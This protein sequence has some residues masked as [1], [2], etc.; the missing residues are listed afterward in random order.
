MYAVF[1]RICGAQCQDCAKWIAASCAA[2]CAAAPVDSSLSLSEQATGAHADATEGSPGPRG[3]VWGRVGALVYFIL[4]SCLRKLFWGPAAELRRLGMLRIVKR[5]GSGL[6]MCYEDPTPSILRNGIGSAEVANSNGKPFVEPNRPMG[7]ASPYNDGDVAKSEAITRRNLL[8][9]VPSVA[10]AN[11]PDGNSQESGEK[12]ASVLNSF[13]C[14]VQVG[15]DI[16][17]TWAVGELELSSNAIVCE[18]SSSD[19]LTESDSDGV[20]SEDGGGESAAASNSGDCDDGQ[21][22]LSSNNVP[23]ISEG[24]RLFN[25]FTKGIL[26][27]EV[28]AALIVD[29]SL[30]PLGAINPESVE[31]A[32]GCIEA[33]LTNDALVW[34]WRRWL[35][36]VHCFSHST[37]QS[38]VRTVRVVFFMRNGGEISG[39]PRSAFS[40]WFGCDIAAALLAVKSARAVVRVDACSSPHHMRQLGR[41]LA[42]N[43]LAPEAVR[44]PPEG[45]IAPE[46]MDSGAPRGGIAFS[47]FKRFDRD[48]DGALDFVEI[49]ELQRAVNGRAFKSEA[50]YFEAL[51]EEALETDSS[52]NITFAGFQRAYG[53]AEEAAQSCAVEHGHGGGNR[54]NTMRRSL[55]EDILR[56]GLGSV[57][58]TLAADMHFSADIDETAAVE[59]GKN[60]QD[61]MWNDAAAKSVAILLRHARRA[62]ASFAFDSLTQFLM[63]LWTSVSENTAFAATIPTFMRLPGLIACHISALERIVRSAVTICRDITGMMGTEDTNNSNI[64]ANLRNIADMCSL[65]LDAYTSCCAALNGLMSVQYVTCGR[66]IR[67]HISRA[68]ALHVG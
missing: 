45:E 53:F 20:N 12:P 24:L 60:L 65:S 25:K 41:W 26:P 2:S 7:G 56:L 57:V 14:A 5:C 28:K 32:I 29:F 64:P 63:F 22:D 1:A 30:S 48:Q 31:D 17:H 51:R 36:G 10:I 46:T 58:D 66:Q 35:L 16:R 19:C 39:G 9:S 21:S 67:L 54:D 27:P 47:I 37:F 55:G 68:A 49:N 18:A 15:P 34:L 42:Y 23:L 38:S 59:I 11:T 40:R 13:R 43:V 61:G 8:A 44:G 52:G 62:H 50:A 4:R 6:R 3:F 33:L